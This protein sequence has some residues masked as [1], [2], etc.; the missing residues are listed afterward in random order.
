M[1][2]RLESY[3]RVQRLLDPERITDGATGYVGDGPARGRSGSQSVGAT[4]PILEGYVFAVR[5]IGW[6][7]LGNILAGFHSVFGEQGRSGRCSVAVGG[8]GEYGLM[9]GAA[10]VVAA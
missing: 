5:R 2:V 1:G 10:A 6:V 8:G 3:G 9:E 7:P 4:L